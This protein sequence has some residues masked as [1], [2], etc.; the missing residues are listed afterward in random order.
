VRLP[1][2]KILAGEANVPGSFSKRTIN[3]QS[4]VEKIEAQRFTYLCGFRCH[5]VQVRIAQNIGGVYRGTKISLSL[6]NPD[7]KDNTKYL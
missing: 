4:S 1:G 6:K 2:A 3:L 7:P 5:F